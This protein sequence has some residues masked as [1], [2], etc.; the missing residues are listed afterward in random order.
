MLYPLNW[1]FGWSWVLVAF[2]SGAIIGL[3]FHREDFWGGYASFRRRLAR[4]GHICFAALGAFNILFALSPLPK[5]SLTAAASLAWIAGGV[6]MPA[7][8][9]LTAWRQ[10]FRRLFFVP[11]LTLLAAVVLTLIGG[12]L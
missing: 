8:C 4:L 12:L 1:V 6:L 7:V 11:V 10:H 5:T 9:F 2:V 3:M